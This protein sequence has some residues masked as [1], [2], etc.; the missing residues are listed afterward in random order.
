MQRFVFVLLF[1]ALMQA[2]AA[3]KEPLPAREL[4]LCLNYED[5][6]KDSVLRPI[7]AA[8]IDRLFDSGINIYPGVK[9]TGKL[10]GEKCRAGSW[11]VSVARDQAD[12]GNWRLVLSKP[13]KSTVKQTWSFNPKKLDN[14][15]IVPTSQTYR[16]LFV[17]KVAEELSGLMRGDQLLE[18]YVY[19]ELYPIKDV[20][21]Q[22]PKW[23]LPKS[24]VLPLEIPE[25]ELFL[26]SKFI[27]KSAETG[28]TTF[29]ANSQFYMWAGSTTPSR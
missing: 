25:F 11:G 4:S 3:E 21:V 20:R 5:S 17:T 12:H 18:L 6:T 8:A 1:G 22:F 2:S 15:E 7:F 13:D 14:Q 24:V 23:R 9:L 27:A 10:D 19:Q 16:G 26:T 29:R 28:V